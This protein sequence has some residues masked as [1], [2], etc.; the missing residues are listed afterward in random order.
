MKFFIN[1]NIPSEPTNVGLNLLIKIIKLAACTDSYI[2]LRTYVTCQH[3]M[4]LV[5]H[6]SFVIEVLIHEA[7]GTF[8]AFK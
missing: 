1:Q 7:N 8:C 5:T 2:S 6:S 4:S 3:E